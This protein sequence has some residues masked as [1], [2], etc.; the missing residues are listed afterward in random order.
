MD[1]KIYTVYIATSPSGKFYIGMTKKVM[2]ERRKEHERCAKRGEKK[3]IFYKALIKYAFNF[4]WEIIASNLTKCE[5]EQ[6]EIELI[7]KFDTTNRRFGYNQVKGGLSGDIRTEKSKIRWKNSMK[8]YYDDPEYL[9][10]ISETKKKEIYENPEIKER[11]L[12]QVTDYFSIEENREK[13]AKKKGGK[14]FVCIETGE[15]FKSIHAAGEKLNVSY[16]NIWKVLKE[17]RK[18]TKGYTF[19]YV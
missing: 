1:L 14:P 15:I 8:K 5:A 11:L 6:K 7:A 16:Q 13:L 12:K 2:E 18:Q 4:T 10:F 9:K 19:K 3:R 17:K